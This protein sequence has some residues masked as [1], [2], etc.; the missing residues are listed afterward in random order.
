MGKLKLWKIH[1]G[2]WYNRWKILL[3]VAAGIFLF[4]EIDHLAIHNDRVNKVDV[5]SAVVYVLL[6]IFLTWVIKPKKSNVIGYFQITDNE[7]HTLPD[8]LPKLKE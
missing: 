5:I 3:L 8:L 7:R 1:R 2:L 4:L 6:F